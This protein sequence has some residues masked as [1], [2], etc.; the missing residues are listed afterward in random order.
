MGLFFFFNTGDLL[1]KYSHQ[2]STITNKTEE[3]TKA[4]K[5]SLNFKSRLRY[6]SSKPGDEESV[7]SDLSL[8]L[9]VHE[10]FICLSILGCIAL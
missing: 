7:G 6:C 8:V 5:L 10:L 9:Q 4:V 2:H 3:M 1:K